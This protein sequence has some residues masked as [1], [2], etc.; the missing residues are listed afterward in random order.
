MKRRKKNKFSVFGLLWPIFTSMLSIILIVVLIFL[1]KILNFF[2]GSMFLSDIILFISGNML[3]LFFISIISAYAGYFSR[4]R[5]T[6]GAI[7]PLLTTIAGIL[8][9]YFIA[10][11]MMMIN[12]YLLFD[13]LELIY[14]FIFRNIIVLF[15]GLLLISYL[16]YMVELA[17]ELKR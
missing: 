17:K 5:M 15:L 2:I 12:S 16:G 10:R 3:L 14:G 1:I 7:V 11:L 9:I 6:L 8:I 13:V 4:F